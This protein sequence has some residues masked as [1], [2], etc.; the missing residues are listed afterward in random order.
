VSYIIKN[1]IFN[2]L[3]ILV[4]CFS[5]VNSYGQNVINGRIISEIDNPK[6]ILIKNETR[7]TQTNVKNTGSFEIVAYANDTILVTSILYKEASFVVAKNHFIEGIEITLNDNVENLQEIII[8]SNTINDEKLAKI[9][10]QI[11]NQIKNDIKNNPYKYKKPKPSGNLFA[12][13]D[14]VINLL[15]KKNTKNEESI[16]IVTI[17]HADLVNYFKNDQGFL[18]QDL[19][20]PKNQINYFFLF[21]EDQKIDNKLLD[22]QNNFFFLEKVA[23]I[24]DN[25]LNTKE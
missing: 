19:K 12:L 21:F 14:I 24:S 1:N 15:R 9:N 22:K 3:I 2:I 16:E 5:L 20:I 23:E 10:T 11:Q 13:V 17:K 4:F 6:E 25:F 8:D 7:N 18:V